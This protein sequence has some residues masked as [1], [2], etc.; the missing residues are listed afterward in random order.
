MLDGVAIHAD[1]QQRIRGTIGSNDAP[2]ASI[3]SRV[4]LVTAALR[5]AILDGRLRPGERIS[6]EGVA[7]SSAPAG[8]PSARRSGGS[9]ARG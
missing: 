4:D 6:Q 5:D 2:D 3:T 9:R 8:Y 7:E 1:R